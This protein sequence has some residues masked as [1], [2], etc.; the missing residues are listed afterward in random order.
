MNFTDKQ[1]QAIEILRRPNFSPED[2]FRSG[3]AEKMGIINLPETES[4][5]KIVFDNLMVVADK[6]QQ[7]RKLL[8]CPITINSAYRCEKLNKAV[9]SKAT[10]QHCKGEAID[11]VCPAFGNPAAIFTYLMKNKIEVD[12]CLLE[13]TWIHLSIKKSDNRNS[14]AKLLNGVYTPIKN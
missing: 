2:F 10:S 6:I 9:G 11:F 8:G 13:N 5:A 1:K 12:Q 3:T 7:I 4:E 14:F